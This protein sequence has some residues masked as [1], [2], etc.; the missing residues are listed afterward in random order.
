RDKYWFWCWVLGVI[1]V[2]IALIL[3]LLRYNIV[4]LDAVIIRA[5]PHWSYIIDTLA[6]WYFPIF[7]GAFF[8][9]GII[10]SLKKIRSYLG[11]TAI[12]SITVLVYFTFFSHRW[13]AQRYISIVVPAI[14]LITVVGLVTTM[15]FLYSLLPGRNVF[16]VSLILPLVIL[17]GPA[18]SFKTDF[19]TTELGYADMK[20]AYSDVVDQVQPGDIVLMQGP[21]FFYWPDNS[22]PVYLLGGYKSL[23]LTEFKALTETSDTGVYVVYNTNHKRHLSDKVLNYIAKHFKKIYQPTETNVLIYYLNRAK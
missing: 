3:T 11:L 2:S 17:V 8:V 20:T 16:R 6:G 18:L 10:L 21:R 9:L 1:G 7:A 19:T 4:P 13:D 12:V 15:K 14:T 5:Q 22:I 23:S